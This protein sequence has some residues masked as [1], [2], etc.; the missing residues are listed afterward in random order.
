MRRPLRA[1]TFTALDAKN[2][3]SVAEA[4]QG[5]AQS[6]D[7]VVTS[8]QQI[9]P[10]NTIA[11]VQNG[12]KAGNFNGIFLIGTIPA[13][14]TPTTFPHA[15]GRTPVGALELMALPQVQ[16]T[17]IPVTQVASAIALLKASNNQV[18]LTSTAAH[19]QFTLILM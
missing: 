5:M 19:R 3:E 18:T 17:S 6:Q 2:P 1:L 13:A 9:A 8:L 12:A 7:Q 16:Q 14:N 10:A 11:D 4:L 15:L